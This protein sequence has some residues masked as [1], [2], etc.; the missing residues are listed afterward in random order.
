MKEIYLDSLSE[1]MILLLEMVGLAT[2]LDI[3]NHF[4]GES[5]YFPKLK[6]YEINNRNKEIIEEYRNG[7]SINNLS[8]KYNISIRQLKRIISKN[9]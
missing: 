4:E 9:K 5:I 1:E 3:C 2:F 7:K 6:T 8:N